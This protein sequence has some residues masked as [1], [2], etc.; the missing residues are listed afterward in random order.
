M[1]VGVIT[2]LILLATAGLLIWAAI[3]DIRSFEIPNWIPVAIVGLYAAHVIVRN[4]FFPE[5]GLVA[6]LPAVGAAAIVLAV[7]TFLFARGMIGGGDVKLL[8]AVTLWPG[9]SMLINLLFWTSV[10]GGIL[11]L[12]LL[13]RQKYMSP[14]ARGEKEG[15]VAKE[16]IPYG[17]AIAFGGI[18]TGYQMVRMGE[19]TFP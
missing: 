3:S 11:A 13:M 17:I 19:V 7:F 6:W 16:E 14:R 8:S 9:A 15:N 2:L 10:G 4:V 12:F 18:L 1:T 5:H